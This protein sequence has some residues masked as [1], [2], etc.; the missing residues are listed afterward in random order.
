VFQVDLD[1]LGQGLTLALVIAGRRESGFCSTVG[2][3]SKLL[4]GVEIII[5]V[6]TLY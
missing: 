6:L 2:C 5:P 3:L 1:L 4:A